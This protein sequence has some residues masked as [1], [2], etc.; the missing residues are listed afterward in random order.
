MTKTPTD[1]PPVAPQALTEAAPPKGIPIAR[2]LGWAWIVILGAA[3]AIGITQGYFDP[4]LF[5]R[6]QG[7]SPW[8]FWLGMT[9]LPLLGFPISACY[10]SAGALFPPL[11]AFAIGSSSLLASTALG[12]VIGRYWMRQPMQQLLQRR[13]P[14]LLQLNPRNAIRAIV[15]VRS[16]PAL[17]FVVQNYGLGML[18]VSFG[19]YLFLSWAIQSVLM[20]AVILTVRGS[21]EENFAL[22][23]PGLLLL[24]IVLFAIRRLLHQASAEPHG[25]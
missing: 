19:P 11:T 9:F 6:T 10:L 22:L 8:L 24:V 1:S 5:Q 3:I 12:Y 16:V 25:E 15:L 20:V 7:I 2:I 18:K 14:R 17:P 4:E 23:I 13:A 21:I